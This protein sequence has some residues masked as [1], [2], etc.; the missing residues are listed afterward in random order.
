MAYRRIRGWMDGPATEV[1]AIAHDGDDHRV[2]DLAQHLHRGP[3]G[4]A[5]RNP[6][7]YPLLAREP[8]GH[9]LGVGLRHLD[10]AVHALPVADLRQVLRRPLA[11]AGYLGA[12]RRL[13][14]DDLD[15]RV[16]FL[17]EARAAHDRAG[18]AHARHQVRHAAVG[19][20]PDLLGG[21]PAVDL[22]VG[23]VLELL[24]HE[25][26]GV[27]A[28]ELAR[29]EDRAGHALDRGR[30]EDFRSVAREQPLALDAHV[31][32]HREDQP[33][34]LHGGG[35]REPDPRVAAGRLDDRRARL[36][37]PAAL[38][39]VDHRER[40]PVLDAAAGIQRLDFRGHRRAAGLRHARE[41]H[42]R[43]AADQV[44]HRAGDPDVPSGHGL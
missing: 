37:Q 28:H 1:A 27:L 16:L 22:G 39:V 13:A 43:G 40:D 32:R 36:Q 42:H 21:R 7:E 30:Q 3:Q 14:A 24:G 44:E 41:P 12:F 33:I 25:V 9:V 29:R 2:L 31:V 18:G 5:G 15:L 11:Y 8:P 26:V 20:A 6:R 19:V 38:G 17:E 34:A 4:A 23:G 10:H 35:H